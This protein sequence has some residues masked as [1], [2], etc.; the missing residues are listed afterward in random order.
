M[1]EFINLRKIKVYCER[2]VM[3]TNNYKLLHR[4]TEENVEKMAEIFLGPEEETR[5][6]AL[7]KKK[8]FEIFLRFLADPG[9]QI[10]LAEETRLHRSTICK[11]I[12][13]VIEKVYE[14]VPE[15]IQFPTNDNKIEVAKNK[16]Q[17][18]Y[19]FPYAIGAIDCTHIQ[20]K[21]PVLYGDEFINR[22]NIPS[23]NVQA[24]C[25]SNEIFTSVDVKYPGSNAKL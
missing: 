10:G 2:P 16:W 22:K 7:S 8:K 25:N 1:A 12:K 13:F 17:E 18:N 14:K 23:I 24:T 21:K 20:I 19:N 3:N 9:Y 15:W 11:T 6:G 4:F 5:G